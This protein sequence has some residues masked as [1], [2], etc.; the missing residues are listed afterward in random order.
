MATPAASTSTSAHG[1]EFRMSMP[2]RR[3]RVG[4]S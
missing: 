1:V 4:V 3:E 2:R